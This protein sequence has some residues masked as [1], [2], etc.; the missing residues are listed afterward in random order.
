MAYDE[1]GNYGGYDDSMGYDTMAQPTSPQF[2]DDF[3]NPV[4]NAEEEKRKREE[5]ER[6]IEAYKQQQKELGSEVSHKQEVTTYA[7]GSR[8]ITTKQEVPGQ[9]AK[10]IQ[11]VSPGY[12]ERIAQQES[13]GRA[14]IGYHDQ[15]KSSAY[16]PYGMTTAGYEDARRANPNLPADIRQANPAQQTQAQNAYTQQNAKYL[17][18]YGVPVNDNTLQAAHFLGAKGL[19]DY[20]K[21]GYISPQAAAANGGLE[22]VK[23]IVDKRLG[24]QQAAASG[25]VQPVQPQQQVQ[26]Q[27]VQ[28]ARPQP[29]SPEAQPQAEPVEAPRMEPNSFDEFGT[30]VFSQQQADLD[31]NLK[32][33][34]S[35][36][37]DP[38]ALM[39]FEGPE[40]MQNNAKMRA[41]DL[42]AD[43]RGNQKAQETLQTATPTDLARYLQGKTKSGE[44]YN[45]ATRVRAMLFS[46][47]G[48]KE[49]AMREMNKLDTVGTDKYVQGPDGKAYLVRQRADGEVLGGYNAETGKQLAPDELVKVNAGIQAQKGATT[50]TGKMQDVTTGEVYYERTTPQGI[51]LVD[52]NGK[53]YKG[54]SAN[55]RP[56]GIGSDIATQDLLQRQKLQNQLAYEPAIAAASKGASYL[57]EFNAKNGTNFAIAGRDAQGMPLLVDQKTNQMVSMPAGAPAAAAAQATTAQGSTKVQ[58]VSPNAPQVMTPAAIE[59]AK[60]TQKAEEKVVRE[61]GEAE[62]K[63]FLESKQTIGESSLGGQA[64]G[65][66]RRQQL[67]L[68]KQNPSILNIMNGTGTQFDQARNIITRIATGAYTDENKEALYADIKNSGM[69]QAEQAALREFANLNTGINAKTLKANSGAGS[70]SNAEQQANKD[71]NIGNVDR[72][73]AFA[74]LAGLHRS[75]FSGDLAA[76][77]QAFLDAHPEFKTDAQFN[78]AWQKEEAKHLN[79]YRAIA[80]ARF[81]VMGKPPEANA[82]KEALAAYKDRIFKAFEAYPAPQFDSTT[83]KWNYQTANA[84]RAAALA[85]LGR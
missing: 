83:G 14:D 76:S 15:T 16:G 50:H 57:A 10:A 21:T 68:I 53:I 64:I 65:N 44:D 24:G 31:K 69:G 59:S 79:T 23:R 39:N 73:P 66:A 34:E 56:F 38:K 42:L 3:G 81:D 30:P 2:Y 72:I 12:N 67:D 49:L 7:D 13:G 63:K 41:A 19:S 29:V 8:T 5:I 82:S 51:Q 75:Q 47:A 85:I 27:P 17:Q 84:Q 70:I 6:Q 71:A 54:S 20:L 55:L 80:K 52:N 4:A 48:Q 78:S 28:Q 9:S 43:Q 45:L 18:N 40:W 33:Y 60:E 37:N 36:Q 25:A 26:Q 22:N 74:A 32:T 77:K 61:V 62:Q 46:A 35:I 1:M 11:P 58:P